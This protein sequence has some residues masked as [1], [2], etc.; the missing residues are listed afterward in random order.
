MLSKSL[1][2]MM[3]HEVRS[4]LKKYAAAQD[5]CDKERAERAVIQAVINS[6]RSWEYR[7]AQREPFADWLPT[8]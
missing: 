3:T 1:D 5:Q 7:Q 4:A 6:Y 2:D 8:R